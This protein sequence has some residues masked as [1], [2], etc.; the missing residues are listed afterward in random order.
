MQV[1]GPLILWF[2]RNH[3][4]QPLPPKT[5]ASLA[6]AQVHKGSRTDYTPW[7]TQLDPYTQQRYKPVPRN[8]MTEQRP[9]ND[10]HVYFRGGTIP[11]SALYMSNTMNG[12]GPNNYNTSRSITLHCLTVFIY[13][14][15]R[16][17]KDCVGAGEV[18]KSRCDRKRYN[19]N[20]GYLDL[21]SNW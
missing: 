21:V 2:K 4:P 15:E 16:G 9:N 20:N 6:H 13:G 5:V 7:T 19:I 12:S 3:D 11:Y 10:W 14:K 8:R 17:E 1:L 18:T